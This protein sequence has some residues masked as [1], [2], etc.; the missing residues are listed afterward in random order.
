MYNNNAIDIIGMSALMNQNDI[1]HQ[2]NIKQIENDLINDNSQFINYK[3]KHNEQYYPVD[4]YKKQLNK[5]NIDNDTISVSSSYNINNNNKVENI[6]TQTIMSDIDDIDNM[7][8]SLNITNNNT[9]TS[10]NNNNNINSNDKY[11]YKDKHYYNLTREQQNQNIVD[12][13]LSEYDDN[14]NFDLDDEIKKEKKM[15]LLE[16]ID[17]LR[18]DMI[19]DGINI[20]K[21]EI[22]NQHS[23]L[24]TIENVKRLLKLKY[25]RY[26]YSGY[27]E[28]MIVSGFEMLEYICDGKTEIL[29]LKPDLTDY[30]NT[31]R[32]KLHRLRHE[33]SEITNNIVQQYDIGPVMRILLSLIPGAFIHSSMRKSQ[34]NDNIHNNTTFEEA[35]SE[36]RNFE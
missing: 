21:V 32:C 28:D 9:N 34:Y 5:F 33:T 19:K 27:A 17:E 31:V 36:I 6:D 8:N 20:D 18:D 1:D 35:I 4:D 2:K 11:Q 3:N 29:G 24:E 23:D 14:M 13:A 22:V 26:Q 16:E 7:L 10:Y 15:M 30:T 12:N 25:N